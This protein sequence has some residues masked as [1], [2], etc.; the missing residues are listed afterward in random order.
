MIHSLM[1][2][3]PEIENSRKILKEFSAGIRQQ[4]NEIQRIASILF[5]T[6][7]ELTESVRNNIYPFPSYSSY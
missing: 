7:V 1:Y 2:A 6:S 3:L 5:Y 4:K